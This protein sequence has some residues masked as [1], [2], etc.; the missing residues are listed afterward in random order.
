MKYAI[1]GAG[2]CGGSIGAFLARAGQDVTLIARGAHLDAIRKNG[3]TVKTLAETFVVHPGAFTMD[4]YHDTP[5]VVFVC[6]KGYS[7]PDTVPFLKRIIGKNTIVIPILNIYGTGARLQKHLPD[8]VVTD[9][10]IYIYAQ[11][12]EPGII[13]INNKIFRVVF[14]LRHDTADDI[15]GNV[16]PVLNNVAA[17]LEKANIRAE[18]SP[19][20]ERDALIKFSFVAPF[21]ALGSLYGATA[22]DMQVGGAYRETFIAMIKEIMAMGKAESIELPAQLVEQN[23][24]IMD[25][26]K[27]ESTTSMQRDI[28]AGKSSEVAGL[29]YSV[30]ERCKELGVAS[31]VYDEIADKLK[32]KLAE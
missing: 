20:I 11:I 22:K 15:R 23:L 25:K 14:G 19:H 10:C 9:G 29:V 5:D 21:A 24:T 31:P 18:V 16:M 13:D 17:D 32:K 27:P 4:E 6:V 3:L 1:V 7:I 30:P 26:S 28:A 8:N 12:A 2:G